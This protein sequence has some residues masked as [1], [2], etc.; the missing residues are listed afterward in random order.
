MGAGVGLAVLSLLVRGFLAATAGV[1]LRL[2]MELAAVAAQV[3]ILEL[4]AQV[5]LLLLVEME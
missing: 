1:G 2:D 3:D 5:Q 4:A